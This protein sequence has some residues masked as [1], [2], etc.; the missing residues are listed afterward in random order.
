MKQCFLV[1]LLLCMFAVSG[2]GFKDIDK[3]FFVLAI[4]VDQSDNPD[5]PY[6]VSLKL[7]IP[8][9]KIEPGQT[10]KFQLVT[11]DAESITEAIR[12]LKSKVDKELDF[13]HAK[14]FVFGKELANK[15]IE[16]PL[17]WFVRRRDIQ[18]IG[19]VAI[20]EPTAEE[21]LN[22]GAISER[23]PANALFLS[24]DREGTESSYIMTENLSDFYRRFTERGK[25]PYLPIIRPVKDTFEIDQVAVLDKQK[26]KIILDTEE[27]RVLNELVRNFEKVD[28]HTK[29]DSD[30]FDIAINHLKTKFN[31]L[32]GANADLPKLQ[33]NVQADGMIEEASRQMYDDNW[34]VLEEM[35]E[36][37]MKQRVK[38]LMSQLQENNVDPIG[39]GLRY[40]AM[41]HTS[42][43]EW[44]QWQEMY[45]KLP[46][47]INMEMKILGSGVIK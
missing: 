40:R 45:P 14:M 27:T 39:F 28:I 32:D 26:V 11:Q 29:E 31:I 12:L 15:N 23:L 18:M 35:A 30:S 43:K 33:I 10:N 8:S 44:Q 13:G 5:K 36:R 21:V 7:G 3:R 25:D 6:H 47:D 4:G 19:F 17:D 37:Q 1:F 2:C 9:P 42:K 24:F 34:H 41:G 20:G 38:N 16:S 22:S 46:I